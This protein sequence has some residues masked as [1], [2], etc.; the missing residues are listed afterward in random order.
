MI[1]SGSIFLKINSD[2]KT[3][4]ID[5]RYPY[6]MSEGAE[7]YECLGNPKDEDFDCSDSLIFEVSKYKEYIKDH[8]YYFDV[9]VSFHFRLQTSEGTSFFFF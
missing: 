7:Y 8:R 6:G 3:S 4:R 2:P 1:L 5:L 9:R